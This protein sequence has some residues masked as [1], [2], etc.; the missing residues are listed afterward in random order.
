MNLTEQLD[1]AVA[2]QPHPDRP[3]A[4]YL[5][6]GRRARNR[7]LAGMVT[8]GA[9]AVVVGAGT[10]GAALHTGQ[11]DSPGITVA[12]DG[13]GTAA[14]QPTTGSSA[15]SPVRIWWPGDPGRPPVDYVNGQGKIELAPGWRITQRIDSP[16]PVGTQYEVYAPVVRSVALVVTK[17]DDVVW[18]LLDWEADG[19]SAVM[20]DDDP[21]SQG[22]S[23]L[24]AWVD[25]QMAAH[26]T[27]ST[28][29]LVAFGSDGTLEPR[30]GITVVEQG[31]VQLADGQQA[32]L[33]RLQVLG[34][35]WW[36]VAREAPGGPTY[37]P[38]F[39]YPADDEPDTMAGF[40]SH[41]EG[42]LAKGG[43]G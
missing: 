37:V 10:L 38:V 36:L 15:G 28:D 8:V 20:S 3:A 19:S 21:A 42:L 17:G 13:A 14:P 23:S 6:A 43:L 25:A 5:T 41:V 29:Q 2:T 22:F 1:D 7:Q 34:H 40:L 9:V 27:R 16:W 30:N 24:E 31:P 12:S 18:A 4:H 32:T 26:Q 33:A 39:Y 11:P 35:E